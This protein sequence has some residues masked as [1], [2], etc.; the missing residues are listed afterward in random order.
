M[1]VKSTQNPIYEL[2][3][4]GLQG[5]DIEI[6]APGLDGYDESIKRWSDAAEKRAVSSENFALRS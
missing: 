2:L 5:G 3:A 6:L 1:I 4:Q